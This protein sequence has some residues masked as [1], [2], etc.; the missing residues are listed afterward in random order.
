MYVRRRKRCRPL[1]IAPYWNRRD[2]PRIRA[3]R[4]AVRD[5]G[6]GLVASKRHYVTGRLCAF[7]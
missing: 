3:K 2:A 1:R 7:V 6:L 4:Q 5:V